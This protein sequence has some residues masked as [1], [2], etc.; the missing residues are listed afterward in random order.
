MS[1]RFGGVRP[2]VLTWWWEAPPER[3]EPLKLDEHSARACVAALLWD[4]GN[5]ASLRRFCAG[6]FHAPVPGGDDEALA[7]ALAWWIASGQV[8]V[9]AERLPVLPTLSDEREELPS[10]ARPPPRV[11]V[12][13]I[14]EPRC[15]PCE[16]MD[17]PPGQDE[18]AA[19]QA[20]M[21]REAAAGGSPLI[22]DC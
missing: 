10:S 1:V 4:P 20:R 22:V 14:V 15:G 19:M 2:L 7:R 13:E 16:E 21:L 5:A 6:A 17:N 3:A 9:A 18:L 8:R 11:V 12:A